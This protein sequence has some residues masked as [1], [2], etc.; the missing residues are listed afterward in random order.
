[1]NKTQVDSFEILNMDINKC[2]ICDKPTKY[3]IE[4]VPESKKFF[5]CGI[6]ARKY[7]FNKYEKDSV[8]I[9]DYKGEI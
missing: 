5:V 8:E 7:P 4:R 2:D 3:Y 9:V 1:M 6:H